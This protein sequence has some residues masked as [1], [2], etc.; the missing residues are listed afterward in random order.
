VAP[1]ILS[2]AAAALPGGAIA[3]ATLTVEGDRIAEVRPG[4]GPA[5]VELDEGVLAPGFVDLQVNGCFGWDFAGDGAEGVA[6]AT[7]R[8]PERGVTAFLPTFITAPVEQLAASVEDIAPL[9]GSRDAVARVI[10]VHV[11]GPFISPSHRGAHPPAHIA[12]PDG[13]AVARLASSGV[14]LVTLAPEL[15]GALE[16]IRAFRAAGAIVAIGH[17]NATA[18]EVEAGIAAGASVVTHLYNGQ[19]GLHHREPGVVGAA[20]VDDR[21]TLGLIADLEHVAPQALLLA[22]RA[23]AGRIALVSDSISA[24]GMPPGRYVLSGREVTVPGRGAPRHAGGGLAGATATLDE[25]VANVIRLGV[26]PAA[27]IAAATVVPAHAV[28]AAGL[29]RLEAGAAADLVWLGDDWRPRRTWV[30]GVTAWRA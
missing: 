23:A 26:D 15:P 6:A 4:T 17:S 8:L 20:L 22:F 10:G 13:A 5:D 27:A 21:L 30:A 2:A 19:R 14:R 28:G 29:G 12:L 18:A 3:P 25:G 9:V 24:A 11:E 16:A 1:W 7:R